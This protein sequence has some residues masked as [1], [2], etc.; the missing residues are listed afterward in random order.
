MRKFLLLI[1]SSTASKPFFPIK[2]FINPSSGATD[3]FEIETL[4]L[5]RWHYLRDDCIY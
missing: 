2:N 1:A 3:E 5:D 4:A